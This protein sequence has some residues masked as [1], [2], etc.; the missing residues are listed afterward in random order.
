M[1]SRS[2]FHCFPRPKKGETADATLERGL[3][4][5][6]FMA[7]AGLVLAPEV[8]EWDVGAFTQGTEELRLLQRRL[9]FTELEQNELAAHAATFGPIALAFDIGKLRTAGATP[10]IYA[11]Q[12]TTDSP[13]SLISTFCVRGA[14]RTAKSKRG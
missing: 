2:F 9:C 5:L 3:Q 14:Y 1:T 7:T 10:V 13:L 6:K 4:I 12:G 8:V 11:P